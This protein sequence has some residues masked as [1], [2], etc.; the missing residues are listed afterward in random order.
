[1]PE[2]RLTVGG[3]LLRLL[4]AAVLVFATYNPAGYSFVHWARGGAAGVALPLKVLAGLLLA[5]G[6]V[7]AIR[8][9]LRS[10]GRPG[11][12]L[13]GAIFAAVLWLVVEWKGLAV[14]SETIVWFVL[15]SL[16][17]TLA[18][19]LSFSIVKRRLTGQIDDT[20]R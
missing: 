1:M 18:V 9:T 8:S 14:G 7:F 2:T 3:F 13:A 10:L 19:G 5:A 15:G 6:W 17:A 12:L 16:A 4:A 20:E 11:T